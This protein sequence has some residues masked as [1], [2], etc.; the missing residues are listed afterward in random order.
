MSG[1]SVRVGKPSGW[2]E[3]APVMAHLVLSMAYQISLFSAWSRSVA[4]SWFLG[5]LCGFLFLVI[6]AAGI[7]QPKKFQGVKEQLKIARF[8]CIHLNA[9]D[10]ALLECLR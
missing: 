5:P 3:V 2:L 1:Q 7:A 6:L 8:R 9:M 4:G 10:G